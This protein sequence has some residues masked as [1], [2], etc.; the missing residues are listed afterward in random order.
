MA[1]EGVPPAN[2]PTS[3]PV[4]RGALSGVRQQ[5]NSFYNLNPDC[6]SGGYPTLKVARAPQ[7]G[8]VVV[9]QGMD[10]A[11]FPKDNIRSACNG[12][13]VPATLIFYTS[14]PGFVGTDTVAFDRIGVAGGYGYHDYTINVR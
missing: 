12:R 7:H 5:I 2:A 3:A 11:E 4:V 6:T 14:E 1:Q 8:Q 10:F 9:E 13:S